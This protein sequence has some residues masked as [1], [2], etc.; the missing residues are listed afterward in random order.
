[1]FN[2]EI[3]GTNI[4][5]DFILF[6]D[7]PIH[8][9]PMGLAIRNARRWVDKRLKEKG[10]DWLAAED[11]PVVFNVQHGCWLQIDSKKAP[12]GRSFLTYR[13]L[14]AV[15]EGFWNVLYLLRN[16]H[17]GSMRIKVANT[18]AGFGAISVEPPRTITAN[19]TNS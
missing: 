19:S 13:T 12:D 15:F 4:A 9:H 2:Y 10:D 1:M 8:H 18:L 16:D 7:K 6:L 17:A 11:E 14:R 3:P 5:V